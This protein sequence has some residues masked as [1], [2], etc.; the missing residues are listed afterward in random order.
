MTGQWCGTRVQPLLSNEGLFWWII[1]VP[2]THIGWVR[3]SLGLHQSQV[4]PSALSCFSSFSFQRWYSAVSPFFVFLPQGIP[5]HLTCLLRNVYAGQE[6]KVR[7]RH[8]TVVDWFQIGKGVYQGCILSPWSF[9]LYTEYIVWNA[10]WM[11]YKL[12]S[13][14][15]G[16]ISITS[17]TQMTPP[18]QEK[19]N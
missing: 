11:K 5:N 16:E 3:T 12:E 1:F 2:Q 19:R 9:N 8:G 17:D 15:L 13:R 4:A 6:A 7:I 18:L 14:L 10:G